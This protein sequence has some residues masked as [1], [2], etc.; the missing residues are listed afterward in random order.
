M[1]S[2][3][4]DGAKAV[5]DAAPD[6]PGSDAP[7]VNPPT[8]GIRFFDYL[9]AVDISPDGR[10]AVFEDV[11]TLD[12]KVVVH[13]TVADTVTV[14][15]SIGDPTR[16]IATGISGTG[17]ITGMHSEPVQAGA[18]TEAGGWVDFGSPYPTPCNQ[19]ISAGWDVSADGT[20]IVGLAWNACSAAAFLWTDASGTGTFTKLDVLGH[21]TSPNP[22]A[23]RATVISDDGRVIAGF[24][25][26]D[27]I[28]RSAAVWNAADGTGVLLDPDN[29]DT[30]SEVLAISADGKTLVGAYGTDGFVY[31]LGTGRVILQRFP[32][33]LGSDEV[34]PNATSAD[35]GLVFGGVGSAFF[36]VPN[37]F[38][39][40]PRDGM[41]VLGDVVTAAGIAMP[42]GMI[43]GN[44]LGA[45]ADGTVLIGTA[46]DA[47]GAPKTFTLRLPAASLY[48]P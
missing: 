30:P 36:T 43:L 41:R 5:S 33:A 22:P 21:S 24:A 16:N 1:L 13:D 14:V 9:I 39:W 3:C 11:S 46:M 35:G 38:I 45:S 6:A 48:A 8:P 2:A 32:I 29:N 44:V 20:K 17:R 23:N 26:H 31:T 18:W 47:D 10:R 40:S 28:D 7:T 37:A 15:T 25:E 12:G 4:S 34:F 27:A 19:D 42:T